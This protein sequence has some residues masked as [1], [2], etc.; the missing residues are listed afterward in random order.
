VFDSDGVTTPRPADGSR[1]LVALSHTSLVSG[2]E[3]VLL[4]VLDAAREDGWE[5]ACLTPPGAF[6]E[7]LEAEGIPLAWSPD[8][9][10]PGGPRVAAVPVALARGVVA[11][12]RLRRAAAGADLVLANS[13]LALPALRFARLRVPAAW[14]V[15]DVIHRRD[16]VAYLRAFGGGVDEAI[17]VSEAAA[18]PVRAAGIRTRVV[19]HGV[20]WPVD[21][22]PTE[23]DGAPVVGCTALLTS[24]KGQ[25]VLLEAAARLRRPDVRVELVGG[26]FPK[27]AAYVE[28]LRARAARPDLAGRVSFLGHVDDVLARIRTWSV[29]V[30]ASVDPEAGP[31]SVLEYM[32]VGVPT[33]ATAH[34]GSVEI[35]GDAGLLVPPGDPAALAEAIERLL[36][37]PALY[38]RCAEAG[39]RAIEA[40]GFTVESFRRSAARALREIASRK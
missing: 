25:D 13:I 1:R 30:S 19:H 9:K 38:R 20:R 7:R 29:G 10:L 16:W 27:D 23:R 5:P 34:G 11:A 4:R 37:D 32:S 17:A 6:A 18:G 31:L 28:R 8:L 14:L 33:V 3:A 15:H 35:V 22:A 2:A 24:W 12:R 39:P 26:S 21:P 40:R 36:D